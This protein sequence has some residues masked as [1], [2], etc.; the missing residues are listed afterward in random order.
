MEFQQYGSPHVH[1]LFWIENTQQIDRDPDDAVIDFVDKYSTCEMPSDDT[2]L[3][4]I[5]STVQQH[6]KSHA[7]TCK[8]KSTVC[9]FNFPSPPSARTFICRKMEE[10]SKHVNVHHNHVIAQNPLIE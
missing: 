3:A 9:R 7:K 1:C 2:D 5:V 4:D 10:K 8:E 6:S